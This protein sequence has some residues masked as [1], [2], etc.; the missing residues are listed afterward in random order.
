MD[1]F[2][3]LGRTQK[4][5]SLYSGCT[6]VNMKEMLSVKLWCF[7]PWCS[8][9]LMIIISKTLTYLLYCCEPLSSDWCSFSHWSQV[10]FLPL[11]GWRR[12][13]LAFLLL[14]MTLTEWKL[15]VKL[16]FNHTNTNNAIHHKQE[17][18]YSRLYM[19][20]CNKL[21]A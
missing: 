11:W 19:Q 5:V 2:G 6:T 12:W 17:G 16:P 18:L 7:L 20:T 9:I 10:S 21:T 13:P 1:Q 8:G 4:P 3:S 15:T 14:M